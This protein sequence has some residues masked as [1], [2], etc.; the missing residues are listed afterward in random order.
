M[1]QSTCVGFL[2]LLSSQKPGFLEYDLVYLDRNVAA[3]MSRRS[4]I[5]LTSSLPI[6]ISPLPVQHLPHS[7]HPKRLPLT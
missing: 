4:A 1:K 3:W 5:L 6:Q 7:V 2:W